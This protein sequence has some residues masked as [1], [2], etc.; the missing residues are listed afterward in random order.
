MWLRWEVRRSGHNEI[1]GVNFHPVH[2]P[3]PDHFW[4][5]VRSLQTLVDPLTQPNQVDQGVIFLHPKCTKTHLRASVKSNFFLELIPRTPVKRDEDGVRE[6]RWRKG[7]GG[8]EAKGREEEEGRVSHGSDQVWEET[9]MS[10]IEDYCIFSETVVP[11]QIP[12][13]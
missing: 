4:G 7:R 6:G 12:V 5:M 13:M 1:I 10:E 2:D 9:P 8:R 11:V 3:L